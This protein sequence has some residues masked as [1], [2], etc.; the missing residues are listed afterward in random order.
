M[1]ENDEQRI[2]C[3]GEARAKAAARMRRAIRW[4]RDDLRACEE[5]LTWAAQHMSPEHAVMVACS[6][7]S[8]AQSSDFI[9]W[10]AHHLPGMRVVWL[11][12]LEADER[13]TRD[14]DTLDARGWPCLCAAVRAY[15]AEPHGEWASLPWQRDP[16]GG[17]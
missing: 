1:N 17:Q 16:K 4:L 15:M 2:R 6:A 14:T 13:A 12:G 8:Y 3:I 7:S 5:G 11:D 10:L 9:R